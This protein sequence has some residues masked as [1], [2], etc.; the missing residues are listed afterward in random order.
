M[1]SCLRILLSF[2]FLLMS[3]A[4]TAQNKTS[5][6]QWNGY[7]KSL[8][9]NVFDN[10]LD[11]LFTGQLIHHRL[12]T[13]YILS[14]QQI[15]I[16][17]SM[18]NRFFYGEIVEISPG[19]GEI[20]NEQSNDYFNFGFTYMEGK[21]SVGHSVFDRLNVEYLGDNIE[22]RLGRQRINWGIHTIWNPNDIFNAFSFTDFDYEERPGSDALL[23]RYYYS[24]NSSFELAA[25][26]ADTFGEFISALKWNT[27]LGTYDLQF[28]SGYY[29]ENFMLGFGWAGNAGEFGFKGEGSWFKDLTENG[30][31]G[32]VLSTG[33]DY[34]FSNGFYQ[35]LG[36]LYNKLG[37]NQFDSAFGFVN[38]VSPKNIYPYEW[39]IYDQL[40]Y[41]FHPLWGIGSFILYSPIDI[42]SLFI[43]AFLNYNLAS[44]W[45][46]SFFSQILFEKQGTYRSPSQGFFLRL[47]WS[48]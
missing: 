1:S 36:F 3:L 22:I 47:K 40:S 17:I 24:D 23:V 18:R 44:N 20:I 30:G 25:K 33:L 4:S 6:W 42:H 27:Q 35:Q 2:V 45:D 28:I 39:V 16:N 37:E 14:S 11:E 26:A 34:S 46:L 43:Q 31:N 21:S 29:R 19:F 8:Q 38:Q 41:S 13:K 12:N 7:I 32:F 15:A 48:Y 5:L 9:I 10:N